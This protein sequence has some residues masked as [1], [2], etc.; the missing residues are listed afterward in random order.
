[1]QKS[2][3]PPLTIRSSQRFPIHFFT[4][5]QDFCPFLKPEVGQNI[6]VHDSPAAKTSASLIFAFPFHSSSFFSVLSKQKMT[7]GMNWLHFPQPFANKKWRV[8]WT[9]FIFPS[10]LQTE[11][12]V[13]R[14][15]T[16]F[17]PV[18]CKQRVTCGVNWLPFP[19]PFS[20]KKWHELTSFSP[21]LFKQ[22]VTLTWT[23]NRTF[24]CYNYDGFVSFWNCIQF[25]YCI[26]GWA[27]VKIISSTWNNLA[28]APGM[29]GGTGRTRRAFSLLHSMNRLYIWI[30]VF[31]VLLYCD[32]DQSQDSRL[33]INFPLSA[34][35]PAL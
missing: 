7:F 18:L 27:N 9:D 23:E 20:S 32:I 25:C 28:C 15:L 16:S 4:C 2:V 30:S 19:Q 17:F 29:H 26:D 24:S 34:T 10:P 5:W 31:N 1:M 11:S 13:W 8:A 21:A 22:K 35:R 33:T 3:F 6:A 14:E 12:D